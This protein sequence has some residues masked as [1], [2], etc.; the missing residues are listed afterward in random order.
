MLGVL[1]ELASARSAAAGAGVPVLTSRLDGAIADTVATLEALRRLA[2]GIHPAV[3]TEAGLSAALEALADRAPLPIV[4]RGPGKSR[5]AP[6]TEAA[7]FRAASQLV[8]LAHDAGAVEVRLRVAEREGWLR[9]TVVVD[10]LGASLDTTDVTDGILAAGGD[11]RGAVGRRR[12]H[13]HHGSAA[14]R[15]IVVDD[16]GIARTGIVAMLEE[17]G[18]EVVAQAA[19]AVAL[20]G[21]VAQHRPDA[22]VL[23]I[24][25]PP[26]HTNEGLTAATR[27]RER[28]PRR[29]RAP[30]VASRRTALC[31]PAARGRRRR[32]R[33]PVQ[34]AG[35]PR[36]DPRGRPCPRDGGGDACST[37][38]SCAADAAEAADDPLAGLSRGSARSSP[39]SPR[40]CRTGAWRTGSACPSVPSRRTCAG[41]RKLG[42]GRGARRPSPGARRADAPPEPRRRDGLARDRLDRGRRA[43]PCASLTIAH[44]GR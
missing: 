2:R 7:A 36:S 3:L 38:P 37:R 11:P 21:L 41:L 26:T 6:A 20:F 30:A 13:D 27:L 16:L 19:D 43:A 12:I 35:V 25:M 1:H 33:L 4:A 34:G 10:G 42:P 32:Y 22:V 9:M 23:D 24:R 17:A 44:T 31:G 8:A 5:Y 29:C 18:I 39:W 28:V 40:G 15:V 14:M